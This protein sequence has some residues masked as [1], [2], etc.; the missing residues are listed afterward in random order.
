MNTIVLM[1]HTLNIRTKIEDDGMRLMYLKDVWGLP[2]SH[3][4]FC[5]GLSQ[6]RVSRNLLAARKKF[7]VIDVKAETA[8]Q[9]TPKEIM[10]LQK[11]PREELSDVQLVSFVHHI[12]DLE[13]NHLLYK[14]MNHNVRYRAPSLCALG[15][16][17]KHVA[18]LFKQTPSSISIMMK[19]RGE[20]ATGDVLD[21]SF[22][23]DT[24]HELEITPKVR[25]IFKKPSS[26]F[27]IASN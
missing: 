11:L 15:I 5:E 8:V 24:K 19:R 2:Q 6:S 17:Q 1:Y 25:T 14:M 21:S 9:F 16:Q 13:V 12:L 18:A 3:I 23:F 4:A 22:R 26:K 10:E 27:F 7:G 20:R